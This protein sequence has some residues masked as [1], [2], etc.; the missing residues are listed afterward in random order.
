VTDLARWLVDNTASLYSVNRLTAYLQSLGHNA[1]KAAV[2][3]YL[4]WFEDAYFLFTVRLFDASLARSNANPKRVYCV[5]HAL[6]SSVSPGINVNSGHLL[7][8]LVFTALRRLHP[9]IRYYRTKKGR[10]VDFIVTARDRPPRLV[11][12]CESLAAAQTRA[13]ETTALEEAMAELG[14]ND[15]TIVTCGESARLAVAAGAIAV[16]PAWRF[17]LDLPDVAG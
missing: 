10:E 4:E 11:Q 14:C 3:D 16:V 6:V 5:D 8:N 1:P 2:A 9:E 15:A 13:R 12:V 17:L 7:E